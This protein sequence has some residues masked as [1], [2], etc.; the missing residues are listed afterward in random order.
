MDVNEN[1]FKELCALFGIKDVDA[2]LADV[3]GVKK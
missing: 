2:V 3:K 1:Q